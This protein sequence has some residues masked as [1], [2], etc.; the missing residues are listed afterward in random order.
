MQGL[1]DHK[2]RCFDTDASHPASTSNYLAFIT[3]NICNL[4]GKTGFLCD[5]LSLFGDNKYINTPYYTTSPLKAASKGPKDVFN[6][7]HSQIRINIECAF[8]MLVNR[9]AM[10][11]TPISTNVSL[12]KSMV[13][14]LYCL[15]NW[16]IDKKDTDILLSIASDRLSINRRGGHNLTSCGLSIVI[17]IEENRLDAFLDGG[18]HFDDLTARDRRQHQRRLFQNSLSL[19]R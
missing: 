10:L 12:K 16:L 9:W 19:P 2:R 8:E 11:K 14:C 1:C 15:H 3:S 4:L 7:Y 13:R 5:G 17:E 18:D 6:L